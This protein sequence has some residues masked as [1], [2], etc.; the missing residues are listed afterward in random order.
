[1]ID[2]VPKLLTV[3]KVYAGEAKSFSDIHELSW[4]NLRDMLSDMRAWGTTLCQSGSLPSVR[5][6]VQYKKESL[7]RASCFG[8]AYTSVLLER[9][10]G[11]PLDGMKIVAAHKVGGIEASWAFGAATALVNN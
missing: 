8:L 10:Y 4:P 11:V 1:M 3:A 6:K 2:N 9:V 7:L 5:A